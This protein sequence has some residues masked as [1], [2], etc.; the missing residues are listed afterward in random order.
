[1]TRQEVEQMI[2]NLGQLQ[3]QSVATEREESREFA[4]LLSNNAV[5][6]LVKRKGLVDA[7]LGMAA[8]EQLQAEIKRRA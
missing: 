4:E 1:M 5:L 2:P 7:V 3:R 8:T 6:D